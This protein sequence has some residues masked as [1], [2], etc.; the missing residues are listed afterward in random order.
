MLKV[1]NLQALNFA[2]IEEPVEDK[3]MRMIGTAG[4]IKNTA[5]ISV[6]GRLAKICK[7]KFCD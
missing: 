6:G 5:T 7:D 1:P 2:I 4:R 3:I